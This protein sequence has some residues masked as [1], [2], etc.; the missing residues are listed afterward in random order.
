MLTLKPLLAFLPLIAEVVDAALPSVPKHAS[1]A[2]LQ[3]DTP[4]TTDV[5]PPRE[6]DHLK[7]QQQRQLDRPSKTPNL[8]HIQDALQNLHDLERHPPQS[9]PV[10]ARKLHGRFLHITDLHPDEFYI[11]NGAVSQ[12]CHRKKKPKK[13]PERAGYYGVPFR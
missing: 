9:S 5:I 11:K 7:E 6:E 10:T 8:S 13:D 3:A 4:H 1:D 12:F 2:L